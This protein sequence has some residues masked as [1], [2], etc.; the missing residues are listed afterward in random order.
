MVHKISCPH[1]GGH[2]A[3]E[4][5]SLGAS[6]HCPHCQQAIT[7]SV[8]GAS[9]VQAQPAALEIAAAPEAQQETQP[10]TPVA[11]G[12]KLPFLQLKWLA[13]AGLVVILAGA[14]VGLFFWLRSSP[15]EV[16]TTPEEQLTVG[17]VSFKPDK[18]AINNNP[19][20]QVTLHKDF[21]VSSV[22]L[23]DVTFA[24]KPAPAEIDKILRDSLEQCVKK[25]GSEEIL[26]MAFVKE[27]A[28][29]PPD[30]SG[31]L[32]WSPEEKTIMPVR[33]ALGR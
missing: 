29:R 10:Q 4:E 3:F 19:Q 8:P 28:L 23:C 33:Q 17:L 1:C 6:V 21:S 11:P 5:E 27:N 18:L 25:D 32:V 15:E 31:P 30:Y 16:A 22:Y 20:F 14:G 26:A 13:V 7:L 9:E 12:K 24:Q 2:I